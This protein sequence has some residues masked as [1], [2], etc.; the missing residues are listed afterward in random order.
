MDSAFRRSYHGAHGAL[1]AALQ[2]QDGTLDASAL[3][4]ELWSV[5]RAVDG[6]VALRRSLADPSRD[7]A[8]K[9]ALAR[10]LLEGKIGVGALHVAATAAAQRWRTP[11]DLIDALERLGVEA[12]LA[13]A[14]RQGRL[15]QVEDELFRFARIVGNHPDLQAAL[16]DRRADTAAKGVLVTRLLSVKAA[17]ETVRLAGQAVAGV[18]GRRFD[19]VVVAYLDQISQRRDQVT[20]TVT[21]AV[22]LTAE[23]HDRL[24]SALSRQY[25]RTVSTQVVIDDDVVGGIRVEIG[26]EV[27]DGTVS[28]RLADARRRMTG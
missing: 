14:E 16:G 22:P 17:P 1:T 19:R 12:M 4:E 24:V 26:D 11:G 21:T 28:Q 27:I 10:R 15:G 13:H 2:Q 18:R 3:A 9:A 6:N 23:Q 20:A 5:V 8:D 7:G 25:G